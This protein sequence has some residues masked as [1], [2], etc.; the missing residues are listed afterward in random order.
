LK[1]LQSVTAFLNNNKS[2][3]TIQNKGYYAEIG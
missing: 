3:V 1:T 2:Y